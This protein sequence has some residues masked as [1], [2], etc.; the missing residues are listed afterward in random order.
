MATKRNSF[1]YPIFP[2]PGSVRLAALCLGTAAAMLPAADEV[3]TLPE[4]VGIDESVPVWS[5]VDELRQAAEDGNAMACFQYA[6][7][8]E[9]GDQ[10]PRDEHAAFEYYQKAAF[11]NH[12]E[13]LF[14]VGKIYHDGLLDQT[15]NRKAGFEYYEKAAYAGSAEATYN[16]GAMLVSGRGVKRDYVEGLAW[17]M[18]A[19]ERGADP[20]SVDQVK[21]RLQRYPDRI[22]RAEDRLEQIKS[23]LAEGP[24]NPDA[25]IEVAPSLAP[26][27]TGLAKPEIGAPTLPGFKP[28]T[29]K[30]SFAVPKISIP[31]PKPAPVP[32][33]D[34]SPKAE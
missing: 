16:V 22:E 5:T 11:L 18:L 29:T 21:N 32:P 30:P 8:L 26:P 12:P 4:F 6:Q 2:Y 34:P 24:P 9:V 17:L 10:V 19:A 3:H 27:R 20:G 7:L 13:A 15:V 14:Q 28:A 25:P 31:Q 23:R 1:S 33:A